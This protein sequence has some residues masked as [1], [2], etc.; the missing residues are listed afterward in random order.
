[1]ITA[2]L[3]KLDYVIYCRTLRRE[4]IL[5]SILAGLL[6]KKV[7]KP[8]FSGC[9]WFPLRVREGQARVRGA[10]A[11]FGTEGLTKAEL[12]EAKHWRKKRRRMSLRLTLQRCA[13][14]NGTNTSVQS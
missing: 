12:I 1:M 10:M 4:S 6:S 3:P 14:S 11:S 13:P 2:V 5:V 7:F 9:L 8:I